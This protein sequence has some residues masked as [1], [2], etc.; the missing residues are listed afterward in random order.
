MDRWRKKF[1]DMMSA[2][3]FAEE[4]EFE[5]AREILKGNKKVLLVVTG[6]ESDRKSFTYALN[7]SKRIGADLE[8]LAVSPGVEANR[9]LKEFG[10]EARKEGV[11]FGVTRKNG[12]IK[13]EII[14]YTNKRRDI[15]FV[16]V[17]SEKLLDFDC[18]SEDRKLM[19]AWKKLKC[20]LVLISELQGA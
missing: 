5:A 12:C 1:E 4:G 15:Q 6:M 10:T 14:D 11:E 17:E 7:T 13:K 9:I 3:A 2:A 19:G 16:V 8:V 20:P 18:V